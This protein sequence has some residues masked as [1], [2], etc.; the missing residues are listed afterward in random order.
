MLLVWHSLEPTSREVPSVTVSV[1]SATILART[2]VI[3]LLGC[4]FVAVPMPKCTG[5]LP[6]DAFATPPPPLFWRKLIPEVEVTVTHP[7]ILR[8]FDCTP[9][10][11]TMMKWFVFPLFLKSR[12]NPN[13]PAPVSCAGS[14]YRPSG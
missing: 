10:K 2:S 8:L 13:A 6:C 11:F 7:P 4:A 3:P 14:T 12:W 5:S 1:E 9:T